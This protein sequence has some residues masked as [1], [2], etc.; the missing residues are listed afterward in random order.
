MKP[1]EMIV[2]QGEEGSFYKVRHGWFGRP[3]VLF[4]NPG[5]IFLL[6]FEDMLHLF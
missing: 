5:G 1:R 2:N 4:Q 3:F 6:H